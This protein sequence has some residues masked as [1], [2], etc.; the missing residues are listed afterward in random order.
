MRTTSNSMTGI[1]PIL[2]CLAIGVFAVG[3]EGFMIAGVLPEIASELKVTEAV[4]GYLVTAFSLVYAIGSPVLTVAL[5]RVQQ[6]RLIGLAMLLF[7]LSNVLAAVAPTYGTLVL[8][9]VALAASASIFMPA[10]LN[11]AGQLV[12]LDMR[13]RALALVNSGAAIALMAG[14]PLGAM[15]GQMAGWR[16]A[17]ALVAVVAGAASLVLLS[18]LPEL[19]FEA[20]GT[21][22]ERIKAIKYPEISTSLLTT[23]FW[24]MGINALYTFVAV[25]LNQVA[26]IATAHLGIVLFGIG[27]A[28]S[29]GAYLGGMATDRWE[30]RRVRAAAIAA[31]ACIYVIIALLG[32]ADL[33]GPT[34]AVAVAILMM[35]C[36]GVAWIFY[37]AQQVRLLQ[38]VLP[39]AGATVVSLNASAMYLGFAGGAVAGAAMLQGAHLTGLAWISAACELAGLCVLIVTAFPRSLGAGVVERTEG[40][41]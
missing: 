34:S 14:V 8:A 6:R 17:F 5:A 32:S 26:K 30:A 41:A 11:A 20:A 40:R 22:G 19:T 13:G 23:L 24:A 29:I 27:F 37:A 18:R 35:I 3:T 16:F 36:A 10:A 25:Y 21:L 31:M 1:K 12:A 15:I 33:R 38:L 4:A 39:A 7:A 28:S 9:R 2:I